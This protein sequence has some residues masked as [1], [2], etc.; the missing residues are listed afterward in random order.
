MSDV[1]KTIKINPELFGLGKTKKNKEKRDKPLAP[2]ISPNVLKN[3]LLKRIKDHKKS[4]IKGNSGGNSQVSE[5]VSNENANVDLGKYTDEF[6]DS[7]EY[8]NTISKKSKLVD[9]EKSKYSSNKDKKNRTLKTSNILSSSTPSSN[10]GLFVE[11]ELPEEL[12]ELPKPVVYQPIVLN[13]PQISS[14]MSNIQYK[15]DND[16]PHGCL[17]GGI[18]PTYKTWN[19]TLRFNDA[20]NN[21]FSVKLNSEL[22]Q[23][24]KKLQELK[25]KL[26]NKNEELLLSKNLLIKNENNIITQQPVQTEVLNLEHN[27][28]QTQTQTQTPIIN[29]LTMTMPNN[30]YNS[31]NI[32]ANISGGDPGNNNLNPEGV[33]GVSSNVPLKKITKKTIKRRYKLGL[34]KDKNSVGILIKD[35]NTRKRITDAQKELRKKPVHEIKNYLRDHGLIKIGSSAPNDVVR[36]IFEDSMLSGDIINNNRD[37]L[38]HN[39]MK[40]ENK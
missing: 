27:Q 10:V 21:H 7:L 1:R 3:K 19:K 37:T 30:I 20:P 24:E 39:F 9:N 2:I 17:K 28:Q 11:T 5:S 15:V 23:R 36:K 4:E 8:L 6:Y 16:V 33:V 12:K 26:Q 14:S 35:K 38:L 18:K 13:K 40:D 34:S 31:T 25:A 32:E 29:N 22:S